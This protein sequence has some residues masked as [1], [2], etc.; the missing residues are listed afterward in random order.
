MA[1]YQDQ[2]VRLRV[3]EDKIDFVMKTF[4]VSQRYEHPLMPGQFVTETRT[5][6]DTYRQMKGLGMSPE[7]V[8]DKLP[9]SSIEPG[10][11]LEGSDNG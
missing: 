4:A 1:S 9:E 10:S 2:E 8:T 11:P 7:Q 5:L 6:L 3:L